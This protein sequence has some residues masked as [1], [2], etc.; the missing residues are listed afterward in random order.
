MKT[1]GGVVLQIDVFFISVAGSGWSASRTG[2]SIPG[3]RG[4]W[5]GGERGENRFGRCGVEKNLTS[6]GTRTPTPRRSTP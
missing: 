4:L 3:G 5:G 6:M 2:R 1:Y